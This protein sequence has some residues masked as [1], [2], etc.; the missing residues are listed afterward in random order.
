MLSL[1]EADGGTH[2]VTKKG[3]LKQE[4]L[5]R[6]H[7]RQQKA[8]KKSKASAPRQAQHGRVLVMSGRFRKK[9]L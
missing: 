6:Q 8:T 2:L 5:K 9:I 1:F 4:Q 7:S 3:F